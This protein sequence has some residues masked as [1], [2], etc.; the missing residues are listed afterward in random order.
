MAKRGR[1][2][3]ASDIYTP[4]YPEKYVGPSEPRYRSSWE[5]TFMRWLDNH[6]NVVSWASEPIKIPYMN[7][8]TRKASIYIPDFLMVYVDKQGTRHQEV[9]E[10]KPAKETLL[11]E[12]KTRGDKLRHAMNMAKWQA[13]GAYCKK[14]GLKFR[15]INENH[16]FGNKKKK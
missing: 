15:V 1:K 8:V 11:S 9:V 16:L 10:V 6:P 2:K 4:T 3:Y 14:H 12:A 5:L 7:P 13:A